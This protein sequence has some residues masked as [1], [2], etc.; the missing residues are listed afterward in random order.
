MDADQRRPDSSPSQPASQRLD[1]WKEIAAYLK[2]DVRSV[3]R[4]EKTEGLPVHRHMHGKQ[5]SVYA[6]QA[7]IDAWWKNGR[8][9]PA[10]EESKKTTDAQAEHAAGRQEPPEP[11]R[12]LLRW[13]KSLPLWAAAVLVLLAGG[14]ISLR[15]VPRATET[16]APY[17]RIF[18]LTGN[19]GWEEFP[20][21]SPDGDR[22]AYAWAPKV[23][24][25]SDIY[26]KLI[27]AGAPLG[28]TKDAGF[29]FSPAWSPDGRF[30]AYFH[31]AKNGCD[32][33]I[34][35]A[36]GGPARKIGHSARDYDW[37]SMFNP[38][39]SWSLDGQYLALA[40][41]TSPSDPDS[42]F[43]LSIATGE[44]IRL[45]RAP[46]ESLGDG[47]PAFSPDGHRL[48]F[49][50]FFGENSQLC[51]L[52]LNGDGPPT[53]TA[54]VTA[55]P[56]GLDWTPDGREIVFAHNQL[57]RVSAE[58]GRPVR[59]PNTDIIFQV[60][61]SRR[62]RRFAYSKMLFIAGIWRFDGPETPAS[63]ARQPVKVISS[64]GLDM[65]P[66]FSPD[67]KKVVFTS[68]RSGSAELWVSD[69][70]GSAPVQLTNMGGDWL[71]SGSPR[72]S[73][74]GSHVAFDS[75]TRDSCWSIY[76][77]SIESRVVRRLT[78]GPVDCSRPGWSA[79][80]NGIYYRSRGQIWKIPLS[81]GPA[82]QVTRGSGNEAVESL[83]GKFVYYHRDDEGA[84][85]KIPSAGGEE[86]RVVDH[87]AAG[88]WSLLPSGICFLNPSH[89]PDPAFEFFEF[90]TG[91]RRVFASVPD[92]HGTF[93]APAFTASPDG[94]W[95]LCVRADHIESSIQIAEDFR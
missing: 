77:V 28:L 11:V 86:Q 53:I 16:I 61:L 56:A 9:G 32:I 55:G 84:V 64:N 2:R 66:Q 63:A 7:E 76:V 38:R 4:W 36:F 88:Y 40:D 78:S 51:V 62:A 10:W 19:V 49:A 33:Y 71:S 8:H 24:A 39:L 35:P 17:S 48:A 91:Q 47:L 31:Q 15:F 72:W 82:V 69:R 93:G 59:L 29:N 6:Y 44:K 83:D 68:D 74:D 41:R 34:I 57:W 94:R 26:V 80:G 22:V 67:G 50:E 85:W 46:E 65:A 13:R 27:G 14:A 73:P 37:G 5:G 75:C 21:F 18:P 89:K 1:S 58:G 70:D 92:I 20:S 87:V 60:A 52:R 30:I 12:A 42:L 23:G 43:L 90:S 25:N 95:I 54:S 45:T 81:G 79:D 3:Q